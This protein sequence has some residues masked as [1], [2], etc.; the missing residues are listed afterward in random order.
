MFTIDFAFVA[1]DVAFGQY[2]VANSPSN[3]LADQLK[4]EHK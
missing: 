3:E 1:V 2:L 4:R